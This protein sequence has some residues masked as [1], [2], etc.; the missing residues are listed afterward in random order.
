LTF[1]LLKLKAI[2]GKIND[3][4]VR[5]FRDQSGFISYRLMR[6]SNDVTVA[7]A[8]WESEELGKAGAENYRKWLR[9]SGIWNKLV[10]T[11]YEGETRASS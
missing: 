9:A 5:V 4:G 3:E 10:L 7:I 8:E 6:A 1:I 11:T 2:F